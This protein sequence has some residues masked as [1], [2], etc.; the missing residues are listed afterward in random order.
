ME[1][2]RI[3][4]SRLSPTTVRR[5]FV[6]LRALRESGRQ[7]APPSFLAVFWST[8]V[9]RSAVLRYRYFLYFTYLGPSSALLRQLGLKVGLVLFCGCRARNQGVDVRST[10]LFRAWVR[11]SPILCSF[12]PAL[13]KPWRMKPMVNRTHN[14]TNR[15]AIREFLAENSGSS[16]KLAG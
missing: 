16:G 4:A 7:G 15:H 1:G 3:R 9:I 14:E 6:F 10:A 12:V 8:L 13:C 11:I 5:L 2:Q